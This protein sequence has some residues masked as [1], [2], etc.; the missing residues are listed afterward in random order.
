MVLYLSREVWSEERSESRDIYLSDELLQWPV[1]LIVCGTLTM[2][3]S[4]TF[5]HIRSMWR[6]YQPLFRQHYYYLWNLHLAFC[7][8]S[9]H[10]Y[11]SRAFILE[12]RNKTFTACSDP[13][14]IS[15]ALNDRPEEIRR[16]LKQSPD[17]KFWSTKIRCALQIH[18]AVLHKL[19]AISQPFKQ[20]H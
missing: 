7:F 12:S 16:S 9:L 3:S 8:S 4:A 1:S 2:S 14:R 17:S 15:C 13:M 5:S 11:M 20:Q 18:Q 19:Q 6:E 10:H